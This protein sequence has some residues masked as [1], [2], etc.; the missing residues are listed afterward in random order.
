MREEVNRS[1]QR[2]REEERETCLYLHGLVVF[3]RLLF[4]RQGRSA[5]SPSS[6]LEALGPVVQDGEGRG[7]GG[8]VGDTP[9]FEREEGL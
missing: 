4:W 9:V 2:R 3:R 7:W 5:I 1:K 6:Q 8:N